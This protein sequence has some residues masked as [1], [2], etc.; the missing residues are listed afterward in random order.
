MSNKN[1][2]LFKINHKYKLQNDLNQNVSQLLSYIYF[3]NIYI[4][5][6]YGKSC[7]SDEL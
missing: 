6:E 3:I 5:H 2:I 7:S 4:V 1:I